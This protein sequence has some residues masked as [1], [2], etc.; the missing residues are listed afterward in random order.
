MILLLVTISITKRSEQKTLFRLLLHLLSLVVV[1]GL[2]YFGGELVYGKKDIST[3]V[4]SENT[5]EAESVMAGKDLFEKNCSFCHFAESTDTKVGPGLKGLFD[6]D[7][8]LVSGWA[9]TP[10]NVQLQLIT[11]FDQMP[12]FDHLSDTE[13]QTL[14]DYLQTL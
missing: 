10:K 5:A 8:M 3:Q 7:K 4:I 6:R 1:I 2:G 9:V 12:P 14:T 13:I 11:P